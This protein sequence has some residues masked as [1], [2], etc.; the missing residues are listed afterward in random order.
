M[1]MTYLLLKAERYELDTIRR[2]AE[3][4]NL[5]RSHVPFTGSPRKHPLDEGRILLFLDPFSTHTP[6]YEFLVEDIVFA[7]EVGSLVDLEGEA[8]TMVRVW[9][10]KG[11]TALHCTPFLVDSL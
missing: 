11:R 1:P 5:R 9:V 4:E 8:V 2:P 10:R 7:E 3:K 6:Y